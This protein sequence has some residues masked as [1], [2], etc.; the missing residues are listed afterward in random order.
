MPYRFLGKVIFTECV[1]EEAL[2]T[3]KNRVHGRPLY[4]QESVT[5]GEG[6]PS[7]SSTIP[8][9]KLIKYEC[10]RIVVLFMLRCESHI[11]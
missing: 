4:Q 3:D 6:V 10:L 1:T 8:P 7:S 9:V 11:D 5:S 2:R